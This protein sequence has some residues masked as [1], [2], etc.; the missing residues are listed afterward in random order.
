MAAVINKGATNGEVAIALKYLRHFLP[1]GQCN[2]LRALCEGEEKAFFRALV[3]TMHERVV[4]MPKIYE[5]DGK[6][7]DA[8]AYL[9]YFKNGADFYITERDLSREQ[10]QAFGWANLGYGG[11][12]GYI[13]ITELQRAGVELDLHFEPTRLGDVTHPRSGH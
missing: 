13:P 11:E 6:G 2:A 1:A 12:L 9:H 4:S 7:W 5:Q 10:R 3:T 8:I